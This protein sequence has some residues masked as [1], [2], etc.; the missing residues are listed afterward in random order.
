MID[1]LNSRIAVLT[2]EVKSLQSDK[3]TGKYNLQIRILIY[4]L[5]CNN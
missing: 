1:Q 4:H 3:E 2:G 5:N